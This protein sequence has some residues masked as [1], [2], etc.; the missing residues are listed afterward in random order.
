M[1][2]DGNKWSQMKM[3]SYMEMLELIRKEFPNLYRL[4]NDSTDTSKVNVSHHTMF[5][6]T[7]FWVF[8]NI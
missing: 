1:P 8:N 5:Y 7:F 4:S 6:E 2:F 3:F